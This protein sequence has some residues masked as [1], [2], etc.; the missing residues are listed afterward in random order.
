MLWL[1]IYSATTDLV[2]TIYTQKDSLPGRAFH[3]GPSVLQDSGLVI[4]GCEFGF[5]WCFK[6]SWVY[7][8]S[9]NVDIKMNVWFWLIPPSFRAHHMQ[10]PCQYSRNTVQNNTKC[11]SA[12]CTATAA[13]RRSKIELLSWNS[14]GDVYA[15]WS[16]VVSSCVSSCILTAQPPVYLS[17]QMS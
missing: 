14:A 3:L 15:I 12:K 8:Y 1:R 13:T 9:F 17:Y 16:C 4:G 2:N 10:S 5:W 11:C 6:L 7:F